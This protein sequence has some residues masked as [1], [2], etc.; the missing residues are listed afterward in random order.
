[1]SAQHQCPFCD[2]PITYSLQDVLR[3]ETCRAYIQGCAAEQLDEFEEIQDLL[4]YI[5]DLPDDAI[6]NTSWRHKVQ[7]DEHGG[8]RIPMDAIVRA[9]GIDPATVEIRVL[10]HV[11]EL[12]PPDDPEENERGVETFGEIWWLA[13]RV[14]IIVIKVT[15][16][17]DQTSAE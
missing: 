10:T 5:F 2:T 9:M 17:A 12:L 11:D 3:C 15:L 7:R 8:V 13:F 6:F 1:M 16:S 14:S 4:A